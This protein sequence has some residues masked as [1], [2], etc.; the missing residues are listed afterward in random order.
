M[1]KKQNSIKK[2]LGL[3][4]EDD[5]DQI[6]EKKAPK[7]Y[8]DGIAEVELNKS[9]ASDEEQEEVD[10]TPVQ[11]KNSVTDRQIEEQK[12]KLKDQE[13]IDFS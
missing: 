4:S 3:K 7:D 5:D 8:E 9:I 13:G 11:K 6:K 12:E 1:E 2:K 10:E